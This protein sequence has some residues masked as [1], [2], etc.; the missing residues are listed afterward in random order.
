MRG[1][2]P[3]FTD[4]KS[5]PYYTPPRVPGEFYPPPQPVKRVPAKPKGPRPGW[6]D[7]WI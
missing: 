1:N 4:P 6:V 3:P 7:G 2:Y 5:H